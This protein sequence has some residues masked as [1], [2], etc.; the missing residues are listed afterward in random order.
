MIQFLL[1]RVYFKSPSKRASIMSHDHTSNE[2]LFLICRQLEQLLKRDSIVGHNPDA[3]W[4]L[5]LAQCRDMGLFEIGRALLDGDETL[6]DT[7]GYARLLY[8]LARLDGSLAVA[9]ARINLAGACGEAA[10]GSAR[11]TYLVCAPLASVDSPWT[12]Q[13]TVPAAAIDDLLLATSDDCYYLIQDLGTIAPA[14]CIDKVLYPL[15][16]TRNRLTQKRRP[17][18][19]PCWVR[20]QYMLDT[21]ALAIGL[22]EAGLACTRTFT[23]ERTLFRRKLVEFEYTRLAHTEHYLDLQLLRSCLDGA[24][25]ASETDGA[26][27]A[28]LY[29]MFWRLAERLRT[30]CLQLL[31]GSGFMAEHQFATIHYLLM[32]LANH[33][34]ACQTNTIIVDTTL[35][36]LLQRISENAMHR[37]ADNEFPLAAQLTTGLQRRAAYWL[38]RM[39]DYAFDE[40]RTTASGSPA[41][42]A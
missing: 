5:R 32:H 23:A 12:V 21:M 26:T 18:A 3:Q 1:L 40:S 8:R 42:S 15:R 14:R 9:T 41:T 30:A 11:L 22:L 34:P 6:F 20:R 13:T 38:H 31:G 33:S 10:R 25:N 19:P 7:R 24:L 36:V 4:R 35:I 28:Q 2:T 17:L 16:L 29:C 39:T 27:L 37:L